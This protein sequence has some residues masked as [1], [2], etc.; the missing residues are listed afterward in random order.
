[1]ILYIFT[2]EILFHQHY[3]YIR[4]SSKVET[5]STEYQFDRLMFLPIIWSTE[6][7]LIPYFKEDSHIR[8]V[9]YNN[10]NIHTVYTQILCI[11]C[12]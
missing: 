9:S 2:N 11:C 10:M 12:L 6:N 4:T 5:A 8:S 3:N 7:L 1:M